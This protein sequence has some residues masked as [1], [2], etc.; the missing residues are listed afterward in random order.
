MKYNSLTPVLL[1]Y[2]DLHVH[3]YRISG[4]IMFYNVVHSWRNFPN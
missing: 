3:V 4:L 1:L 2:V